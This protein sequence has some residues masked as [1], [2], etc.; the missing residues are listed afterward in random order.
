[1]TLRKNVNSTERIVCTA[2]GVAL[3][4]YAAR[5][6]RRE[7]THVALVSAA[8]LVA[9][10]VSGYCP[11]NAV[12]GRGT[13]A[14]DTREALAGNRGIKLEDSVTIRASAT[15]LYDQWRS[16]DRLP[17]LMRHVERVDVLDGRRSHWVMKGPA[18]MRWEWDAELIN[19]VRPDLIAWRSLPGAEVVSAGSVRFRERH[20][21][22][23][24]V[25]EVTVTLQYE[26]TGGKAG[27]ALAW[28]IGQSPSS[29][30]REDL[31]AFKARIEAQEAPTTHARSHG[32]RS[33]LGKIARVDA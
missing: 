6:A 25:T 22:G 2:A 15:S 14:G 17:D 3:G 28:L 29:M 23:G 10:G 30:L 20:R 33:L 7:G 24:Q 4:V 9:R 26:P 1:M 31:R 5:L 21:R 16:L 11:V 18:G 32:D 13:N 27:A 8:A 19:D 12:L